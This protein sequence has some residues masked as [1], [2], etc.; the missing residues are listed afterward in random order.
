MAYS[1]LYLNGERMPGPGD[2]APSGT[3][4][5]EATWEERIDGVG[6]AS[7]IIQDRDTASG[8]EFGRG[9]TSELTAP[10]SGF[11][12][13]AKGWRDILRITDG[14]A[15]TCFWG[16][17]TNSKLDLPVGF[18]WRR[19]VLTASDFNSLF[20][21]R[22]VGVPDGDT[23]LSVDGGATH[24][25]TDPFAKGLDRDGDTVA[26]LIDHYVQ[27]PLL[28]PAASIPGSTY[29]GLFGSLDTT[30]YVSNWI[31]RRI[32]VDPTTGETRLRW[33]HTTLRA[34]ID[35]IRGLAGFPIHCWVDPDL[36]VHWES[37]VDPELGVGGPLSML[38]PSRSIARAA[39]AVL[40][41][42][43]EADHT[44][45][46]GFRALSVT[47]DGTYMPQQAFVNGVTDYVYNGGST[48]H[49]GTGFAPHL[50][51]RT[52]QPYWRQLSVDAQTVTDTEKIAV[53]RAYESFANRSRIRGSVT[54]GSDKD[55]V[56]GW[57][58]GQLLQIFDARL[59][60]SL[61]GASLPI[62]A[63]KGSLKAGQPWREYT[64]EFG[65]FPIARFSQKYRNQPQRL[66][67]A[68][69]PARKHRIYWPTT[70]LR[71]STSYR[72]YSQ[73]V[74]HSDK[75]VRRSGVPVDWSLET[76]DRAG[77]NVGGGSLVSLSSVT[78]E[79]GRTAATL[80]TSATTDLHYHVTAR[81]AAQE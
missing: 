3:W 51:E 5:W 4:E 17:V 76:K 34:A 54:V 23:W 75:P 8:Q 14:A 61:Y 46:I 2:S 7:V 60:P 52:Q 41:H 30:T 63:V 74:D 9:I 19:W 18:P 29:T 72:L 12:G 40:V 81:T 37:L 56:D 11:S 10:P 59:P 65:D 15:G 22:L 64:L 6:Q 80:T 48:I 71:P 26:A 38:M 50:F 70:H 79:H 28:E 44:S 1:D 73:M 35:E 27:L 33:D 69:L 68:R 53:A 32:M 39:P 25:P 58:V 67:S 24:H 77:V 45:S 62:Q 36:K 49:Q 47:Y 20:D 13:V 31:P 21:Q 78:D 16:E 66:T 57:R 43:D 55:R 42:E